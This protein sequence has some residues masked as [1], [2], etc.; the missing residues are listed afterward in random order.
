MLSSTACIRE[1]ASETTTKYQN[2]PAVLTDGVR[3]SF[4]TRPVLALQVEGQIPEESSAAVH[5]QKAPRLLGIR[6]GRTV[7]DRLL[8]SSVRPPT[9]SE[10]WWPSSISGAAYTKVP[11]VPALL[12]Y[13]AVIILARPTSA[14]LARPSAVSRMLPLLMSLWVPEGHEPVRPHV[15]AG[16]Q[17]LTAAEHRT[18]GCVR[19]RAPSGS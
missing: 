6:L 13:S 18:A 1:N 11:A 17:P 2:T 9:F 4:G 8:S 14:I 12:K 19:V 15:C 16:R 5:C 3:P 7:A 10:Q